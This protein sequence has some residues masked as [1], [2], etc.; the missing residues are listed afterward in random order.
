MAGVTVLPG[1][2]PPETGTVPGSRMRRVVSSA[3]HVTI[4]A[5]TASADVTVSA[6]ALALG[7]VIWSNPGDGSGV[8]SIVPA[9]PSATGVAD[10]FALQNDGAVQAI[11]SDGTTA[12]T[13]DMSAYTIPGGTGPAIW[14]VLADFQGGL[15]V[16]QA[17]ETPYCSIV[18]LDGM[19]GQPYPAYTPTHFIAPNDTAW[20][21]QG[22]NASILV[23]PDGTIFDVETGYANSTDGS[24]IGNGTYV[25]GID[26]TTG[27]VK[28]SVQ[29][30]DTF[31]FHALEVPVATGPSYMI[32]GD[33][34]AYF[35]YL[36]GD[37]GTVEGPAH[38]MLLRVNSSGDN[39]LIDVQ[40]W[41]SE[42][43]EYVASMVTNADQGV[44]LLWQTDSFG[45]GMAVTTGTSVSIVAAPTVA[46]QGTAVQN[47]LQAQDGSFV[48]AFGSG[49]PLCICIGPLSGSS[50][51]MVAFDASGNVRWVAPNDQPQNATDDGGV[52]GRSGI[53]YDQ[54]GNA[55]G[56]VSLF[57][58]SW[59]LNAY[60]DGP[61]TQ[62]VANLLNFGVGF[63]P[64]QGANT[65]RN[66]TAQMQIDSVT[67]LKVKGILT[68]ALW[69][70]FKASNCVVVFANPKGIAGGVPDYSLAT[71]QSKQNIT[72]FYDVSNPW[73]QDLTLRQ[74]TQGTGQV[75]SNQTLL[76]YLGTNNAFSSP[77]FG[78]NNQSAIVFK[79]GILAQAQ[80]EFTVMHEL[81][82]HA[83]T[84]W[85]DLAIFGN[86]FLAQKGLWR[87]TGSTA[88]TN[89]TL[90]MST[91]CTCTP[92]NPATPNCQANTA[93]W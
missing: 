75:Q 74:V 64:F 87:Q 66:N 52:I 71:A 29:V 79:A 62:F 32:A 37:P 10:V 43:N 78:Y 2:P 54:N 40:D 82:L 56:Q 26:P 39:D 38:L 53:T 68:P 35:P 77:N 59:T 44:V 57:T 58:Q 84:A 15:I 1:V 22:T 76:A 27:T 55:T 45:P 30:P 49:A 19:T 28:L 61:V 51:N 18:K 73:V 9:V 91:D 47:I 21:G 60:Q 46:G 3:G 13:T 70:K 7:T 33:G 72:N 42:P 16:Y 69:T 25:N 4:T 41:P 63:W 50:T 12:W 86:A 88:A 36:K 6:G 80:P 85:P 81:L 67:N 5:G 65:S 31:G 34:Y 14:Q 8:S 20:T 24:Y 11:A 23:A 93:K 89:I 83:Y 90:W 92:G 17:C 48:G